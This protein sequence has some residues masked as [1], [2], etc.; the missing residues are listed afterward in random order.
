[1]SCAI[2]KVKSNEII[3][4]LLSLTA[5]AVIGEVISHLYVTLHDSVTR[6]K[7]YILTYTRFRIVCNF[8]SFRTIT[9]ATGG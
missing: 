7:I 4:S 3:V 2:K 8:S 6:Y 9:R 5:F 1:M